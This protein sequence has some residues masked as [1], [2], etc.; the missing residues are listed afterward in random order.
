MRPTLDL[1]AARSASSPAARGGAAL[2]VPQRGSSLG[3]GAG[4]AHGARSPPWV[5]SESTRH[6]PSSSPLATGSAQGVLCEKSVTFRPQPAHPDRGSCGQAH[7]VED[8]RVAGAAAEVARQRLAD[9]VVASA[10][11]SARA[12]RPPR[13]RGPAC[14]SRTAPRPPRRTPPARGAAGRRRRGP[15]PS[16]PRARP[17]APRARGTRR[18]AR[19][20]AAPSTS[21][22]RPARTRSS[23]PAPRASRAARRAATRPP[24]SRPRARRR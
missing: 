17:P 8:L 21:R 10:P 9:L 4:R 22:T 2:H 16:P 12:G 5:G 18:R 20:R 24:S 3:H 13:R 15:R 7:R 6:P 14:R 1:R 11:G 19:R 23:S